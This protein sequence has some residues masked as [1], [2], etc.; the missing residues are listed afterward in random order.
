MDEPSIGLHQRDNDKLLNTLKALRDL[1]NTLIV[2]EHDEATIRSSDWVVDL[3]WRAGRYGGEVI[4]NGTS[5]NLL[6]CSASLTAKY[7]NRSP[8]TLRV[9][10]GV[11]R[12]ADPK[13]ILKITG[14]AEH[15]LKDITVEFPLGLFIC[16]TGVS[17][18]GKSTLAY[19]ILYPALMQKLY[20]SKL[21]AGSHKKIEGHQHID[22][23]IVVDQSPIGRTPRSNPA[24]Y[25]GVYSYIRDLFAQL[26]DSKVRGYKPGRFSFNV[27]GGRCEAC[28]GDGI[29]KIEMH[30]LP[31]VYVQCEVCQGERFNRQTLEVKYKGKS[32]AEVLSMPVEEARHIFANIPRIKNI[33]DTLYD[34]GLG[35]IQLGQS[36]TT[37]S[38]ERRKGSSFLRN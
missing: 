22:K 38:G 11:A 14:A 37:L 36:A 28:A 15:N 12:K 34:V 7:L 6:K 20:K 18:S 35:Y 26:P 30:F 32:I 9:S 17:G 27:Q 25:T 31:D 5:H 29:K 8:D 10:L 21:K 13:K 4:F 19:E 16:V 24:T 2:V 23:V 33:L 1:G 3:G